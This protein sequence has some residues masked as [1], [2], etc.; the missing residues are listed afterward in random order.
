MPH[1]TGKPLF[2]FAEIPSKNSIFEPLPNKGLIFLQL[3]W[4]RGLIR[5]SHRGLSL[6]R[7]GPV[8]RT[9]N[10][11]TF[12]CNRTKIGSSIILVKQLVFGLHLDRGQGL[13]DGSKSPWRG[14]FYFGSRGYRL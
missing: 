5:P 13:R 6:N 4:T 11:S 14:V 1:D 10:I 12:F 9:A 3:P 7:D 2:E 8:I